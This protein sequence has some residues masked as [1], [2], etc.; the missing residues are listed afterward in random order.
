M[1]SK[2]L[3]LGGILSFVEFGVN[4]LTWLITLLD[5]FLEIFGFF[6][7]DI[8]RV[9]FHGVQLGGP[10]L[11]DSLK[12]R[13]PKKHRVPYQDSSENEVNS[14]FSDMETEVHEWRWSTA[15][16]WHG[17]PT[18]RAIFQ[19][20]KSSWCRPHSWDSTCEFEMDPILA[21]LTM[22]YFFEEC[23]AHEIPRQKLYS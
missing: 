3:A 17:N 9:N 14:P 1:H 7:G 2:F 12:L 4:L 16:N 18:F 10:H 23:R 22:G 11:V 5:S 21:I 6:M 20:R 15:R 13:Y 8:S 19:S